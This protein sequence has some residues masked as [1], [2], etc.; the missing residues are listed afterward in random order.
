MFSQ[1]VVFVVGA[2]ASAEYGLPAGVAFKT[3]IA[4]A[5]GFTDASGA[6]KGDRQLYLLLSERFKDELRKY[7]QAG[8]EL[9]RLIPQFKSIDEALH[10]FSSRPEVVEIG[11]IAIVRQVLKAEKAS[12]L[13]DL[14]KETS[15]SDQLT[16]NTWIPYFVTMA[17]SSVKRDEVNAAFRNVTLINFNYDRTVE[18]FLYVWLQMKF[19]LSEAEARVA[20]SGLKIIRP[21]GK[22]G[23]LDWQDEQGVPFGFD[24]GQDLGRLLT[25]SNSV[26]TYTEQNLT[27][28]VRAEI[29]SAIN[30]ARMIVFLGFGFHQQNMSLLQGRSAE[31]WRRVFATI[32]M[33]RDENIPIMQE[34]IA[35]IGCTPDN[36]PLLLSWYAHSLLRD[37]EPALVA[38]SAM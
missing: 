2:G 37:L 24:I 4:E 15:N 9:A 30:T 18:H 27:T 1:P 29:S 35:R 33:I 31:R 21:Y 7:D 38:A 32:L 28:E 26:L 3:Q 5:I 19:A 12:S 17:M 10:W 36:P 23:P 16:T 14:Q 25:L 22:V 11:K 6:E 34:F 13:Y 20:V 8:S